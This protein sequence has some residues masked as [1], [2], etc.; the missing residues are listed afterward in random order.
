[1]APASSESKRK[2]AD[3]PVSPPPV[4]R[5]IQS[6]TT[7]SFFT[8]SS[9]KPKDRTT[10]SERS[11][12]DDT[13]ATLLVGRY[14]PEVKEDG[15]IKRRKIAAFDLDST[16]V[17]TSS[18]KT[19]SRGASDWKWWDSCVPGR[20]RELYQDEGYRVVILSNQGGLTLHLDANFKGPK[21]S[22]Q[23]R[24]S[25]FKQKCSAILNNLNLPTTV[26]AATGRDIYRKPSTGMWKELCNDY[27]IPEDE[28]DLENSIFVGDAGGRIA[29]LGK[30]ADGVAAV[31][32]DFSCSDRNFAHNAGIKYHTPEEFFL[33]EKERTFIRDF[34]VADYPYT[35]GN[36]E[37]MPD[38]PRAVFEKTNNQDIVLF[39]GPPGAG[40]STF[41]WRYLKPLSY[42]RINQDTLKSRDKCLHTARELLGEGDSIAI[43]NTNADP[44]TRSLWIDVAK[45]FGIPIRCV[46]FTTPLPVCKHNDTLRSIN[47]SMNPESRQILPK[48]AFDT[49]ASRF[50]APHLK[51]GFQDIREIHFE[52]RGTHADYEIWGRYWV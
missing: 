29:A 38:G 12:N 21:A 50:K 17:S 9:Q 40:K 43:D 23:K 19:H 13:P 52:F 10:W 33:G 20:L 14:E 34:D 16:L 49:F 25:D 31:A 18:G 8:P 35:T 2:A 6:G 27:D 44:G 28:V 15:A 4:K 45:K 22:T 1:M 11:P 39:C 26:Y 48:M 32:K 24:V 7:T 42:E 46:W 37:A 51:E 47:T 5:K 41:Y 3:A 30:R 36:G